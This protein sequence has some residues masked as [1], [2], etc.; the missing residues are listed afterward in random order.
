MGYVISVSNVKG[1]VAKTSTCVA[2]GSSLAQK[3]HRVLLIDLDS[4]ADLT[5][6]AGISMPQ[7]SYGAR[8]LF[9]P[10][11]VSRLGL[12]S[13]I[14]KTRYQNL[15]IIASNGDVMGGDQKQPDMEEARQGFS[16]AIQNALAVGYDF[17]L[18]DCPPAA[19][20]H[21]LSALGV[22]D[23]VIIP[24]QAEYFSANSLLKMMSVVRA[25]R[26]K[27]NPKLQYRVVV[28]MLDL[29]S[30]IQRTVLEE[31]RSGFK[32]HLFTTCILTDTK[33]RESQS[34]QTPIMYYKPVTRGATLYRAL[35]DELLAVIHGETA[36]ETSP[37][38]VEVE[39]PSPS[40]EQQLTS[41]FCPFLGYKDD[42]KTMTQFPSELNI[43]HRATPGAAPSL[44]HQAECCLTAQYTT[45]P[46]MTAKAGAK[47][48]NQLQLN[49]PGF[50]SRFGF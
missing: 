1:G 27:T 4:Q 31:F 49:P 38:D 21:T 28:T 32:D 7:V 20:L 2:L 50:W 19:N 18:M 36:P 6:S 46:M 14:L 37:M 47:L 16:S 17:I 15:E 13:F 33:I 12:D 34:M 10:G 5:L 29:R 3:G 11:V 35:S 40:D 23:L 22:S 39:E 44:K 25:V 48:P 45:C 43:C 9:I 26:Q 41:Q 8:D 42:V 24:T 30:R